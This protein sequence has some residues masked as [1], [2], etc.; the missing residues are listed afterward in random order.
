[1]YNG[2]GEVDVWVTYE[3]G[4]Q[5]MQSFSRFIGEP[6]GQLKWR[7]KSS[8]FETDPRT[9]YFCGLCGSLVMTVSRN[10]GVSWPHHM[11]AK[12]RKKICSEENCSIPGSCN[13]APFSDR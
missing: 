13:S 6:A 12:L 3:E 5:M 8:L 4:Y 7:A 2:V 11:F 1:M 10:S 9:R